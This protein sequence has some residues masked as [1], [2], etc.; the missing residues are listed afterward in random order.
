LRLLEARDDEGNPMRAQEIRDA[1]FTLLFAGH[2]T[3]AKALAW[4][5]YWRHRD[6]RILV[7]LQEAAVLLRRVC[8]DTEQ[9]VID[10]TD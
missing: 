1:L 4:G 7:T 10:L 5:L 2:E 6:R 3:T 8:G 9:M